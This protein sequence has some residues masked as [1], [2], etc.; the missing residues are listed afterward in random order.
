MYPPVQNAT[1]VKA[2]TK[3]STSYEP[4][5]TTDPTKSLTGT[6]TDN[7]WISENTKNTN[8]R[9]HIDLGVPTVIERIYYENG[10]A[11]GTET[12]A[13]AKNFTFWGSNS[14]TSFAELT[15]G[16]DTGWTQITPAQSTFDQHVAS[17]I[18]DPK[19]ITVTNTT[20]YRY[21]AFKFA[22]NY[23]NASYIQIRRIE[24]QQ[25]T[26]N[27]PDG[28]AL[29]D[30]AVAREATIIKSGTYSMKL[31]RVSG[32]SGVI[33][34]K[35]YNVAPI[36]GKGIAYWQ[37]RKVTFSCWVYAT[38]ASRAR[39]RIYDGTTDTYS[40]YHTGGSTWELISLTVT[41]NAAANQMQFQL[42]T[43]TGDTNAYF[44]GAMCVEGESAFA[45][46]DKPATPLYGTFVA[47]G[48]SAVTISDTRVAIT[49]AIVISLNTVGGT[50]GVQPHV[51]T[52]TAGTGFTVVCTAGDTS[53]YNYF[54][55]KR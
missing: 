44:D 5:F 13:G 48:A 35:G 37:G 21:Y 6:Y 36:Y 31:S 15:Y 33:T 53:T 49:D 51:A 52:I 39:L 17:D 55:L 9:F 34:E 40:S 7:E 47:N 32:N 8:Q 20:A 25:K 26:W 43:D 46:A 11:L 42:R 24:L 41:I 4:F 18:A 2:T 12:N 28:W 29:G 1:Y 10:H 27:S 54:L 23:G 19:Y 30:G 16:T 45:F 14:A 3:Y 22:D 50:V 38:V